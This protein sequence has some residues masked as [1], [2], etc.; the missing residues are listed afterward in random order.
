M[1]DK[2]IVTNE[3]VL[4]Q[5]YGVNGFHAIL[6]QVQKLIQA[7]Q[8]RGLTTKIVAL[9]SAA[10]MR[11]FGAPVKKSADPKQNKRAIDSICAKV[12]PDYLMVLG[13]IDVVPYQDLTNPV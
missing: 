4:S 9:D 3:S 10:D 11:P 13:S 2:Y 8:A 12:T 7:D 5:K 6:A 1:S